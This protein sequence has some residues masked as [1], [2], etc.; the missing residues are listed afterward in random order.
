VSGWRSSRVEV[1]RPHF[2]SMT[3]FYS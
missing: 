1:A 3:E 2:E